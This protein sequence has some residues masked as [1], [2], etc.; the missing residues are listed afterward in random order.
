M[1]QKNEPTEV[2]IDDLDAYLNDE[3]NHDIYEQL[4]G[5][6]YKDFKGLF[7]P[8]AFFK[9]FYNTTG[10]IQKN[11]ARPL[12][13]ASAMEKLSLSEEQLW[14]F[15]FKIQRYFDDAAKADKS[16]KI[17]CAEI[18]KIQDKLEVFDDPEEDVVYENP[19]DFGKV[20]EH[21]STL[22]NYSEKLTYLHER[23]VE[24]QQN[25]AYD[26]EHPNFAEKC[27]LEISKIENLRRLEPGPSRQKPDLSKH[28]D[29]RLERV[30]LALNYL[31][32]GAGV[33]ESCQKSKR[34]NF[35]DFVSPYSRNTIKQQLDKLHEKA[36]ENPFEYRKDM[37]M[38]RDYFSALGLT[39]IVKQ[40]ERDL[41]AET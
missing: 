33:S 22:T 18:R 9:L 35:I 28:P 37:K 14:Y 31:L 19:Y 11:K 34:I 20:L 7:E 3:F 27:N 13:V 39:E 1:K 30:V 26:W 36:S 6:E 25:C 4:T 16:I 32:D 23:R 29:A 5:D 8:L 40:V 38:I 41:G 15:L 24:Y 12:F 2:S 17:C 10:F 21:L